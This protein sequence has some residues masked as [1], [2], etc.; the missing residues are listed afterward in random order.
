MIA[1]AAVSDLVSDESQEIL[2]DANG[3]LGVIATGTK[4]FNDV[5][6]RLENNPGYKL[7]DLTKARKRGILPIPFHGTKTFV[8]F[9]YADLPA[10]ENDSA[11]EDEE[12]D[13]DEEGSENNKA[14][15]GECD[16]E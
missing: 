14:S 10:D 11:E 16:F 13:E 1:N 8:S 6:D 3:L 12:E 9:Q 2:G 4:S 5:A 7:I 15:W